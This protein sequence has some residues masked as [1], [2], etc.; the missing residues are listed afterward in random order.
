MSKLEA[1][2]KNAKISAGALLFFEAHPELWRA[3]A[4]VNVLASAIQSRELGPLDSLESWEKAY[5]LVG[6]QLAAEPQQQQEEPRE[7][8]WPHRFMRP[9][10]TMADIKAYPPQEYNPLWHDRSR[11]N[12]ELSEKAKIFR[13]IVEGV[14]AKENARREGQNQ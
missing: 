9:V 8:A 13:G 2:Q 4:N 1:A 3:H 11:V 10:Q 6:H 7:E 14:I 5:A 12:G